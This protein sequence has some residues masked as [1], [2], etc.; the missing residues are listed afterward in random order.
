MKNY[1]EGRKVRI[2]PFII[3]HIQLIIFIVEIEY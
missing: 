3:H 2:K 1:K